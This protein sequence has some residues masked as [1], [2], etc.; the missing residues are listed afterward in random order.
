MMHRQRWLVGSGVVLIVATA[1][2]LVAGGGE[3]SLAEGGIIYVD[4]DADPGGLGT[5][6]TDAYTDL[7]DALADAEAGGGDQIWVA[8]GTYK[9]TDG[10]DR[11]ASFHLVNGVAIYG[12]FAGTE[13]VLGQRDWVSNKTILS[14]NIGDEE[15]NADNSY[16]VLRGIDITELTVLDGLTITGGYA[17]DTA[18]YDDRFGGGLFAYAA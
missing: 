13:T 1:L 4:A 11:T 7:Q 10:D 14:G 16:H 12:G 2:A 6:W 5:S 3:A 15:T 8:A 18:N 9:P 17:Q